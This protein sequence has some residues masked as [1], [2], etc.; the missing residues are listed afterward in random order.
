MSSLPV[1]LGVGELHVTYKLGTE[2]V[3]S[4]RRD[5]RQQG[6]CRLYMYIE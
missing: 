3:Q 6:A 4:S 2:D 5:E 1:V